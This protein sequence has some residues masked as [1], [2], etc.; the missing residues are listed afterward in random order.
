M[1]IDRSLAVYSC[2]MSHLVGDLGTDGQKI[3]R[4]EAKIATLTRD[5]K[6]V[7]SRLNALEEKV[8]GGKV[9]SSTAGGA[10]KS[11][12]GGDDDCVVS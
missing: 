11:Q 3:K 12:E 4:L 6:A 1:Y 9:Q 5:L 8:H 2:L 10:N 7:T